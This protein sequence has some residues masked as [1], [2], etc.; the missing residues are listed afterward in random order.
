MTE[1]EKGSGRRASRFLVNW[2]LLEL[3][4]AGILPGSVTHRVNATAHPPHLTPTLPHPIE[5]VSSVPP[6][7]NASVSQEVHATAL[8]VHPIGHKDSTTPTR[9]LDAETGSRETPIPGAASP[10]P[11]TTPRVGAVL[12]PG[13]EAAFSAYGYN[14]L[15]AKAKA[16]WAELQPDSETVTKVVEAAGIWQAAYVAEARPM[17]WRYQFHN[18]LRDEHYL[19]DGPIPHD[20]PKRSR[21]TPVAAPSPS[22]DRARIV[23]TAREGDEVRV[24]LE[25]IDGDRF[26]R[27]FDMRLPGTFASLVAACGLGLI[28]DTDELLGHE[29][30]A[31]GWRSGAP[32]FAAVPASDNQSQEGATADA[33]A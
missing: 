10:P 24:D 8:S 31:S 6:A 19:E 14:H 1:L 22:S 18:W 32:T 12:P 11:P 23:A 3:A 4:A 26:F 28:N 21:A 20:P 5:L 27:V 15:R 25:G 33:V 9:V 7:G 17:R 2:G 13:F 29:V 16:A 30:V